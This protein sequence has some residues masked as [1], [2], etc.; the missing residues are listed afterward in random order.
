MGR[1][2]AL[3]KDGRIVNV[4]TTSASK[5]ALQERWPE[6][7]VRDLEDVP[8]HVRSNYQYWSERP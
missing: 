2:I 8:M 1:E 3:L 6:Y 7:E 4:V 5:I